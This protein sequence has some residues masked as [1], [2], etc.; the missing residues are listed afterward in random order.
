MEKLKKPRKPHIPSK[1]QIEFGMTLYGMADT[2]GGN[3]STYSR[4]NSM[5]K[6]M[7]AKELERLKKLQKQK[8]IRK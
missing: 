1:Y 6:G 2:Y 7:L 3:Y 5:G 8:G 4:I